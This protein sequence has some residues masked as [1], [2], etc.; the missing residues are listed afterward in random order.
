MLAA[1]APVLAA[2]APVSAAEAPVL[3][4]EAVAGWLYRAATVF[5]L[6]G[7]VD[8]GIFGIGWWREL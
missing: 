3:A 7:V 8:S 5:V 1:E 4:A 2:E 6:T